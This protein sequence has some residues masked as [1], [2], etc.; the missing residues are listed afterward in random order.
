MAQVVKYSTNP[1]NNS[2]KKG[3]MAI[4]VNSIDYGGSNESGWWNTTDVPTGGY[5][6]YVNKESNGP[7][8][9]V[10]QNDTDLVGAA[11]S[12][13][14]SSSVTTAAGA[15]N[16]FASQSDMIVINK[17]Y[18]NIVTSG[19]VLNLDA[20][21]VASY[22]V[23]GTS[24]YDISG[25]GNTGTLVNG[26]TFNTSGYFVFDGTNDYVSRTYNS[27]FDIRSGIT[28][29]VL[30]RRNS[31]F[32]QLSDCF[33][34]SR[35]PS[36]YFYDA[37][38][39][40]AI[41]GDVFIDGVRKGAVTVS[42]PNDGRWYEVVYTY[43]SSN[44]WSVMYKNNVSSASVQ[45]TG[46]S[47]YLID[48][49]NANFQN[50][51]FSSVGKSYF[52]NSL[53]I[54]N[55][56]L[57]ATEISQ[58][59]YGAP[60]VT[61][62]LI[63]SFDGGNLVSYPVTGTSIYDLSVSAYSGTLVNGPTYSVSGGGS[64][65]YDGSNDY[66]T[67]PSSLSSLSGTSGASLSM[68]IKLDSGSNTSGQAGLIQ[69]SSYNN[70][71]GNLYFFTD[72]SRVGGIWLDIFRTDRV[73]TGD[74]QPTFNGTNWHNLTVTC[75]SGSNGWKMY[76]NENLAFQTTGP[77]VVS[78]DVSLFGGFRLGQNSTSRQLKGRIAICNIYN[79]VLSTNEVVQN[80]NAYR[81]RFGL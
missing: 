73:F 15:L 1:V 25:S 55:R 78:V 67:L 26:P 57:S 27:S 11:R 23:S 18:N 22:P 77:S 74:W 81:N 50:I 12:F 42:M 71:N 56:A 38:N 41:Q 39:S 47:N 36:W 7:S 70:S 53:R 75:Q 31:I 80:F 46:L 28:L 69:L 62:G 58:N 3:N 21:F 16:Y 48:S 6:V 66:V 35:P 40:G 45:V 72:A 20:S 24:W 68:W 32:T 37:Y 79:R 52:V 65:L 49:S 17:N 9:M 13:G 4:G 60:I 54:Y 63:M 14:A 59:Y 30:F 33:I 8:I 5:V 2:I 43:N 76:L 64:L 10:P 61:S 51:F 29:Y 34:L 19:L 44:G